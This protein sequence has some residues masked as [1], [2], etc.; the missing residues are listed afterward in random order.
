MHVHSTSTRCQH[1]KSVCN[2]FTRT[3]TSTSSL[4]VVHMTYRFFGVSFRDDKRTELWNLQL[5][6]GAA[7]AGN[8]ARCRCTNRHSR[9]CIPKHQTP[10]LRSRNSYSQHDTANFAHSGTVAPVHPAPSTGRN[11]QQ[12]RAQYHAASSSPET[13]RTWAPT[14]SQPQAA[15]ICNACSIPAAPV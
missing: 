2:F 7:A 12:Q 10:P 8:S 15:A 14:A 5:Y 3:G 13:V 1:H 11:P 4:R 6:S 9:L